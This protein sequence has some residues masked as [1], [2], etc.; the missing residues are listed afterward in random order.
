M[1]LI[2]PILRK[3]TRAYTYINRGKEYIGNVEYINEKSYPELES[4]LF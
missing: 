3:R 1:E 2:S 4:E